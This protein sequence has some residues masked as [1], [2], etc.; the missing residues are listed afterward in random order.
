MNCQIQPNIVRRNDFRR[1]EIAPQGDQIGLHVTSWASFE[2][3]WWLVNL[4]A[5][6]V[7]LNIL[8]GLLYFWNQS[9]ETLST[10]LGD[11]LRK[12]DYFCLKHRGTLIATASSL[13]RSY[14]WPKLSGWISANINQQAMKSPIK[15]SLERAKTTV[16]LM[17]WS[18]SNTSFINIHNCLPFGSPFRVT[19]PPF[20]L[21]CFIR[22]QQLSKRTLDVESY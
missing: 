8:R 17:R 1:T 21:R 11:F 20:P 13:R 19:Q 14:F 18:L 15:G 12:L 10:L 6:T 3:R 9:V 16:S 22:S 2:N 4:L 7:Q 5:S